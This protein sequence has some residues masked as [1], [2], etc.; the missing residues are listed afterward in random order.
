MDKYIDLAALGQVLLT[1]VLAGA[2][3]VACFAL[4]VVG[5]SSWEVRADGDGAASS[6][7][8]GRAAGLV[9]TVVCF[10]IV[11]AGVAFGIFTILNKS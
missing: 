5:W 6:S 9:L 7:P 2:G 10:A 4:G 8:A 1:S 11:V 3:L